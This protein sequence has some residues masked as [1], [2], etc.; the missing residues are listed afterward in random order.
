MSQ[1]I[2]IK[3]NVKRE[4]HNSVA[5]VSYEWKWRRIVSTAMLVIMTSAAIIYGLTTSVNADQD[6]PVNAAE[7]LLTGKPSDVEKA[8]E[9]AVNRGAITKAEET[10]ASINQ[11]QHTTHTVNEVSEPVLP[12][13]TGAVMQP[14]S[15]D[16]QTVVNPKASQQ[17]AAQPKANVAKLSQ[18][19]STMAS[20]VL[21]E[22]DDKS[23]TKTQRFA[24]LAKIA[25][26]ALGAQID[27][28]KISRAVLTRSVSNRE[29]INVFAADIRLSQFNGSLSFFSEL[30]NLQGQH[31]KHVW[32]FEGKKMAEIELSVTSPRYRTYST[33]HISDS[34]V[35]HW[36]V[37]V[38]DEQGLL[39][40]QKE[41]RILAD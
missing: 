25:S 20:N 15:E 35:G 39:I 26:V 17:S 24:A 9:V 31:V 18:Q 12:A 28:D 21:A 22:S 29:P 41:F 8:P 36:R 16:A 40:A 23:Q 5:T 6:K 27:T 30:K 11:Q 4:P 32:V 38:I 34:Q 37:D 19:K 7:P 1:K 33:K 14:K 3:A 10:A 2:V 13:A